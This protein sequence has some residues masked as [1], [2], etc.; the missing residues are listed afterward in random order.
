V[1][2]AMS[3]RGVTVSLLRLAST[4]ACRDLEHGRTLWSFSESGRVDPSCG[5]VTN[6]IRRRIAP[7]GGG[8]CSVTPPTSSVHRL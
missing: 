2:A 3:R 1:M 8:G 4:Q 5:D 7:M 6:S